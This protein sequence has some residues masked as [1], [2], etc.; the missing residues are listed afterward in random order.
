MLCIKTLY[1]SCQVDLEKMKADIVALLN[2]TYFDSLTDN[3]GTVET[4]LSSKPAA[5]GFLHSVLR[6]TQRLATLQT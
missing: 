6:R 1:C 5:S 3:V 4:V 2:E